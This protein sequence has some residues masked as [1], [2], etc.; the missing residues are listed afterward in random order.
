MWYVNVQYGVTV[1]TYSSQLISQNLVCAMGP[2]G[3]GRNSITN[4]FT[5]HFNLVSIESF[6]DS[7]MTKIFSSMV[8]WHFGKGF[9]PA[10]LRLGKVNAVHNMCR[11]CV[12]CHCSLHAR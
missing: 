11:D 7:T 2:P 1:P 8:D 12:L 5:R 9:D 10:F 6:D 4:R 3:G